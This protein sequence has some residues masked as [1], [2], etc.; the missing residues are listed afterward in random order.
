[1]QRSWLSLGCVALASLL[2]GTALPQAPRESAT[3]PRTTLA[4]YQ[5]NFAL[6]TE[7]R[8]LSEPW[9]KGKNVLRISDVPASIDPASVRFRSLTDPGTQVVS[10]DFD[11]DLATNDR[12]LEKSIGK[13]VVVHTR[14]G[15]RFEGLLLSYDARQLVL[16]EN[17]ERGATFIVNRSDNI[18]RIHFAGLPQDV[19]SRPTLTWEVN[20]FKPGPHEIELSYRADQLRW[21]ADYSLVLSHDDASA[22]LNGWATLENQSGATYRDAAIKLIAGEPRVVEGKLPWVAGSQAYRLARQSDPSPSGN[23]PGRSFGEYRLF[24]LAQKLTLANQETKQRELLTSPGV[25][26]AK[27]YVYDGARV[28]GKRSELQVVRGY[29][30]TEPNRN[31]QVLV[32]IENQAEKHLGVTLPR[33][34][35]RIYKKDRDGGV[36]FLGEDLLP[37]S[38]SGDKLLI[39]VGEVFDLTGERKQLAFQTSGRFLEES[40]EIRL[41][42][43]KGEPVTVQVLEKMYRTGEWTILDKSH[44]Y[45]QLD[46]R[47]IVFPVTVDAGKEVVV[48]YQV[49]YQF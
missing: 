34:K 33:G 35:W 46:Q 39:A 20:A 27:V 24:E 23:N 37:H 17:L 48:T 32:E 44:E 31:V 40:F 36:E 25:P 45:Q 10:Q 42:N 18:R 15:Q 13:H 26:I 29:G 4:I 16:T 49:R 47:T 5:D 9:E 38:Q 11:F 21:R 7:R 12:L 28:A 1:M 3:A 19:Q 43:Q 14:G 2:A 8:P 6:V 30:A 22:D 41:R